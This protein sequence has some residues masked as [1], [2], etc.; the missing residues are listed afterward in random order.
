MTTHFTSR[1][2]RPIGVLAG[3]SLVVSVFVISPA[4]TAQ[5]ADPAPDYLASFDACPG[6]AIPPAGFRDVPG[7][8]DNSSDINCIA[9]YG[10]TKGTSATTYAPEDPVIREHMALFLIR[11]AKL[12]GIFVPPPDDTPFTDIARLSQ[13]SRDNISQIY[14]LGITIG[15]S[16]TTYT[17]G[18]NVSR[19]EMALFLQRLMDEMD[20]VADGR[21]LYGYIPDDVD[22]NDLDA[23]IEAPW[24]DIEDVP[25]AVNEAVTELYELGVASGFAGSARLYGPN[26]DMSRADMAA[27]MAAILDHSNLRPRGAT[28]QVSP[29]R[30]ADDFDITAMVSFR[31]DTFA[32]VEDQAVDWF[33]TDD[34]DG[35]LERNGEC[36]IS[37]ILGDGDCQWDDDDDET[38]RDGNIF[39]EVRATAGETMTFYAWVGS[40]NGD[41]FDEDSVDH[42]KTVAQSD[43]GP[44]SLLVTHDVPVNAWQIEGD[45]AWIVDMDRRSSVEITIQLQDETG[46]RL[47]R[48]GVVIDIEVNS[49]EILVDAENV[50]GNRPAPEYQ[51][52]RRDPRDT[53]TVVTDR[54]GE[55]TFELDGPSRN[56]RLDEVTIE[57]DCCTETIKFAWSEGDSVLVSAKPSFR[58]YQYAQYADTNGTVSFT[59]EYD[60]YDQYGNPLRG[61]T[62]R[63]T[64][65]E[66]EVTSAPVYQLATVAFA[67]NTHTAT[68][69]NSVDLAPTWSRGRFRSTL[70]T[71]ALRADNEYFI[72][73]KP[74]IC[75]TS[76]TGNPCATGDSADNADDRIDY[77]DEQVVWVVK[78]ATDDDQ[79][80]L[81]QDDSFAT[82]DAA[83][84]LEVELYAADNK[85]RTFFT[86]WSYESG[87]RFQVGG[88]NATL[89]EFEEQ[90][91]DGVVGVVD[92][93]VLIYSSGLSFFLI[94]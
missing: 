26:R 87:D 23:D 30:G 78:D 53:S 88:E 38:D 2:R 90:W 60:L 69:E 14:Q 32:P 49:R 15:T 1:I 44:S 73:V 19:G 92:I 5:T 22:D 57:T 58:L 93:D 47:E 85:F 31:S 80:D 59:V 75:S 24:R 70:E 18:R 65:R 64:G 77:A 91:R 45:G 34:P 33:Y 71:N 74:N 79:F 54:R 41:D 8:H 6:D 17:P 12:V 50:A 37:T 66:T 42:S 61:H 10:I 35:G 36:D 25:F 56:E 11:L 86:L 84:L 43:K 55:A 9:Y 16:A 13:E 39:T 20:V 76:T 3:L 82:I 62:T 72:L 67:E 29:I 4:T 94:K 83:T 21:D 27:F 51:Q 28:I 52:L 7:R 40:R 89:Q 68:L 48:E 63:Y 46:A 81:L